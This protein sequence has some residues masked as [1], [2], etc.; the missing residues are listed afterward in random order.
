MGLTLKNG[1]KKAFSFEEVGIFIAL[2]VLFVFMSF[3]SPVFFTF[4][5]L[6]NVLRQISF[7]GIIS[8]GMAYVIITGGIDLSV[9]SI[10]ALGG[11]VMATFTQLGVPPIISMAL[12]LVA[13]GIAGSI[14]GIVI[15]KTKI[16][17]F[18]ATMAMMNIVKGVTYLITGGMPVSFNNY[19]DWLGG[20]TILMVPVPIY[21]MAIVLIIGHILLNKTVLGKNIFAV[22][23]NEKYAMLSGINTNK[24]KIFVYTATGVLCALAG[25][26]N[27]CNLKLA[28]T[29]AGS[30]MEMDVIA[31][32]VIGGVSMTGGKGSIRGVLMGAA[33]MGIIRNGFV[34]LKLS[35]YLQLISIGV[36]IVVAVALDQIKKK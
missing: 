14:N 5:N 17:A 21:V 26:I 1:L 31:A 24:I 30:G 27:A 22:G 35:S 18:I 29:A 15:V 2:I 11:V 6:V 28:D 7:I 12:A 34:L 33:I 20:G 3:A 8:V 16:N 13:G 4:G 23:G 36:V 19:L 10:L 32:V 25:T 9:G